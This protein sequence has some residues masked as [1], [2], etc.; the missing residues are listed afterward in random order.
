MFQYDQ[1]N[2]L[3]HGSTQ[4]EIKLCL[5]PPGVPL[6]Q[7]AYFALTIRRPWL[8]YFYPLSFLTGDPKYYLGQVAPSGPFPASTCLMHWT[9]WWE[10]TTCIL[11]SKVTSSSSFSRFHQ[12][13]NVLLS[14]RRKHLLCVLSSS[15]SSVSRPPTQSHPTQSDLLLLWSSEVNSV[16]ILSTLYEAKVYQCMLKTE[17]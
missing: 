2:Y 15:P 9:L 10:R 13:N 11:L 7:S 12:P 6:P 4:N 1:P 16:T 3:F 8:R 5:S 14:L 17:K